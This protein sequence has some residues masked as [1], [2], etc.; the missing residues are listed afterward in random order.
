MIEDAFLARG[1][2]LAKLSGGAYSRVIGK[3][4]LPFFLEECPK[5]RSGFHFYVAH[6]EG[7]L[8]LRKVV[9]ITIPM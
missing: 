3:K 6:S 9:F 8:Y 1:C 2:E 5:R 4:V 7:I